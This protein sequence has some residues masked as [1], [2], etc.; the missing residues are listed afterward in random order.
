MQ[1][2]C[3]FHLIAT[4]MYRNVTYRNV[5]SNTGFIGTIKVK[6]DDQIQLNAEPDNK[7]KYFSRKRS[8]GLIFE[9]K[10]WHY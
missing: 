1:Q 4:E 10:K 5:T 6:I 7:T 3:D 2:F 8:S 9:K